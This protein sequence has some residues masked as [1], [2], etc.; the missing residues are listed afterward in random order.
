[1]SLADL[2]PL[3]VAFAIG[4]NCVSF[5]QA[6]VRGEPIWLSGI[7]LGLLIMTFIALKVSA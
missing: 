4:W 2:A 1:M 5:A 6:L 7:L 3:L